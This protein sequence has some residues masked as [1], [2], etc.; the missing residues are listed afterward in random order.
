MPDSAAASLS[1]CERVKVR[2]GDS[3]SSLFQIEA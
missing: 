1:D 3:S 2:S